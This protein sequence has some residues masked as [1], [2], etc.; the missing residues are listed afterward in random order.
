MLLSGIQ[1]YENICNLA[2]EVLLIK[3]YIRYTDEGLTKVDITFSLRDGDIHSSIRFTTED[4]SL[5]GI[6]MELIK[7][8]VYGEYYECN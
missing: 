8:D 3:S 7:E 5:G 2:S 4:V 1:V 6:S